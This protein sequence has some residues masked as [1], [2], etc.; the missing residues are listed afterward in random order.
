VLSAMSKPT[1]PPAPKM[2]LTQ[3]KGKG[4][5]GKAAVPIEVSAPKVS[6]SRAALRKVA[7]PDRRAKHND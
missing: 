5:D 3:P 2:Q 4:K 7:Q 6:T 1:E